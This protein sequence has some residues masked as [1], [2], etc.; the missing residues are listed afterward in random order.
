MSARHFPEFNSKILL[1]GEYSLMFGSMALSIPYSKY[2]GQ[3]S[4]DGLA[5]NNRSQHYSVKYLTEHHQFLEKEGFVKLRQ[6]GSHAFYKHSD[7]R[8][9][10]VPIHN[11]DEIGRGLLKAILEEISVSREAFIRKYKK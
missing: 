4:F 2:T 6:S 9:T 8:T 1:F 3:M 5:E 10:I 7:G 11:N